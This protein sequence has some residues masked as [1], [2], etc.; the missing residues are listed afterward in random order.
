MSK[1]PNTIGI[2]ESCQVFVTEIAC[3]VG[4]RYKNLSYSE[5]CRIF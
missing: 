1:T 2:M 4:K 5:I 3:L